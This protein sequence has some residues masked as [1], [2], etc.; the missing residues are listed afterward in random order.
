MAAT[1]NGTTQYFSL[2]SAFGLGANADFGI[3]GWG[4]RN[5]STASYAY[6]AVGRSGSANNRRYVAG[7]SLA[8]T[9][10]TNT[11]GASSAT[12]AN[13]GNLVWFHWYAGFVGDALRRMAVNG[14]LVSETTVRTLSLAPDIFRLGA[15]PST[16][17][18]LAGAMAYVGMWSRDLSD[19]EIAD[20]SG[21]GTPGSAYAPRLF[22]TGFID[23]WP[24]DDASG[25]A[26][27]N[28]NNLT[29]VGS[30]GTTTSPTILLT[31]TP[32]SLGGGAVWLPQGGWML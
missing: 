22:P 15:T 9:S 26:L 8:A 10:T 13:P 5:N 19:A 21:M 23:E 18:L 14:A 11:G 4:Y 3:G 6:G 2:A 32:P 27:V 7:T 30:P 1:L 20:L 31:G 25:A 12:G 17:A 24:F 28:G 16:T 29:P